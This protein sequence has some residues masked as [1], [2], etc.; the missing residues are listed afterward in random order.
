MTYKLGKHSLRELKGVHPDLVKLVKLAI[1]YTDQDFTV[2]DGLRTIEEQTEYVRRR[3]SRT[4]KSLHLP[5]DDGY[6]HAVDLVP[7]INGKLRWEL[8]ACYGIAEAMRR[9]ADEL[10]IKVVWGATWDR[11]DGA[12]GTPELLV[13]K[14]VTKRRRQGRRP[15]IDA[16]HFQ[17]A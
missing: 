8:D 6:G 12:Q 3:V 2:H 17:L 7:Y 5:Q 4:M 13:E 15:F 16:P 14:Y 10:G 9:A 1:K 11:L